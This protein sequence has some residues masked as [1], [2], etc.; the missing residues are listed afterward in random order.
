MQAMS[1]LILCLAAISALSL[2]AAPDTSAV[3]VMPDS[4]TAIDCE[5]TARHTDGPVLRLSEEDY[6]KAAERLGVE[7]AVIKAVVEIEAGRNHNG[8]HAPGMP[9]V[10]F[11]LAMFKR[12]AARRGI[13]LSKYHKSHREVF[14]RPDIRRYGSSQ[15]AQHARL[16]GAMSIDSTAAI[17]GTFWGMFQ[18]GGFNWKKCGAS[19]R[20]D[21]VMRMSRSEHDQLDLFVNFVIN[22]GMD[23]FLRKK[24]WAGFAR[25]YNGA[26]YK[27][28]RYDTR[29]ANA[30]RRLR[31]SAA[32]KRQ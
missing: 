14:A 7:T 3:S 22:G 17:D 24:D 4:L 25:R 21:F 23:R 5:T 2:Q 31:K 12:A 18:I 6:S 19:S 8:F 26:S 32:A 15:T 27:K 13:K 1:H 28:R 10:N 16:S 30:Y 9:L 29:M 11:D 20:E